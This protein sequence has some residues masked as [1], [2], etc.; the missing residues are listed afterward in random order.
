VVKI[1]KQSTSSALMR[2]DT[3]GVAGLFVNECCESRGEFGSKVTWMMQRLIEIRAKSP[4]TKS[5]VF[6][7]WA[8][9][10]SLVGDALKLN[11]FTY[12]YLTGKNRCVCL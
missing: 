8:R 10:L 6:S 5:I 2:R 7:Q 3:A 11:G 4:Q 12:S 1:L 9:L